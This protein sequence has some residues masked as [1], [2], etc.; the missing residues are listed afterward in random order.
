MIALYIISAVILFIFIMLFSSISIVV[1]SNGNFAVKIRY[2][3]FTYPFKS[4]DFK[5]KDK[6]IDKIKKPK[7]NSIK[8]LLKTRGITDTL[9]VFSDIIKLVFLRLGNSVK[10]L[11]VIRFQLNLSVATDDPHKTAV[12]YGTACSLVYPIIS[13]IQQ[14]VHWNI[15]KTNIVVKSDFST[16]E[17]KIE[18]NTKIK[19]RMVYVISFIIG[20]IF[21][22]YKNNRV[23][24]FLKSIKK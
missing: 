24:N 8:K 16:T 5:T 2:L 17:P 10:H 15:K 18:L 11:R 13:N 19:I 1:S 6:N 9:G 20:L 21:D 14:K 22:L 23:I 4:R 12:E 7:E 3:F